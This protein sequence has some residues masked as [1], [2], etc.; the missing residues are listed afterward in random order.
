MRAMG[1]R[2]MP[3]MIHT[4][5]H[6]DAALTTAILDMIERKTP[7]IFE[8]Q[9]HAL[10]NRPDAAALLPQIPAQPWSYAAVRMVGLN[11]VGTRKWP[12]SFPAPSL[13][14][15]KTV[16]TCPPWNVPPRSHKP[17]SNGSL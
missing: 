6:T 7:G 17:C 12:A 15:L 14:S 2:W 4:A 10:L 9:I 11:S 3:G 8:A 1:E 16:A 13:P 5:R